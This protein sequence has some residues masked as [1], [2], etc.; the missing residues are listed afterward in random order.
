MKRTT[1]AATTEVA[2]SYPDVGE[3]LTY[4]APGWV[5]AGADYDVICWAPGEIVNDGQPT[6]SRR[7]AWMLWVESGRR[8]A[9]GVGGYASRRPSSSFVT[10]A[11]LGEVVQALG[12]LPDQDR[13]LV[14]EALFRHLTGHRP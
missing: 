11:S 14:I 2:T 10:G 4:Q 8:P 9:P 13:G 1:D 3:P 7:H 12:L 5:V 6:G